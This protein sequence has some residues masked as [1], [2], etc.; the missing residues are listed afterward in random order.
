MS[1]IS[2]S[3]ASTGELLETP[4]AERSSQWDR[5][6]EEIRA[7]T[8]CPL[9]R[10]RIQT[11]IY[12]GGAAPKIVFVGEA[13][14]AAE[15]RTGIPFVGASG[16]RLDQAIERIGLAPEDFG[17]LNLLKCRPPNNRF[18]ALASRTCR[19]FLD[20]QLEW[21]RP[22]VIVTLGAYALHAFDSTA[23]P[24]TRAAGTPRIWMGL[25]LFPLLHPAASLRSSR[26]RA[27]W[28]RDIETLR[29]VLP[30][31]LNQTL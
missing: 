26:F 1:S 25:A 28:E 10:H 21:L 8:R 16:R 24:I 23:P 7:C 12:R 2:R 15:D 20:R 19:P 17:V 30:Q 14:G 22:R 5:L 6:C 29:L 31:W 18:D 27:Q 13:P 9:H 4:D 11:V 3:P